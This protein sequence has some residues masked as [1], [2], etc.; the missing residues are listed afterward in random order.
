[1][2]IDWML[3]I[4]ASCAVVVVVSFWQAHRRPGFDFNAFDL[5]TENG[6]VSNEKFTFMCAFAMTTWLMV[7]LHLKGKMTEGYLGLYIAAWVGPLVAKV[8]F[9]KTDM[10]GTIT[11]SKSSETITTT[12][13]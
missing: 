13:Q 10:P 1:V 2:K 3:T 12:G 9:K 11:A 7:D 5:V 6:K 8:I 4:L